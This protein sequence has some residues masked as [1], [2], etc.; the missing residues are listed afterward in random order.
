MYI[1][2]TKQ[3]VHTEWGALSLEA[4]SDQGPGI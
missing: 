1:G 3:A 2:T 4:D